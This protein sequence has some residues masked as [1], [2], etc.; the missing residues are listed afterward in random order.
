MAKTLSE[1][2]TETFDSSI[3]KN[4]SQV[5]L[6]KDGVTMEFYVNGKTIQVTADKEL[7]FTKIFALIELA[8]EKEYK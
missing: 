5:K 6:M 3:Y 8:L 2:T 7:P 1:L 4:T